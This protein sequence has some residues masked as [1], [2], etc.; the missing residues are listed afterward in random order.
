M[1]RRR[2]FVLCHSI[3]PAGD[4]WRWIDQDVDSRLIIAER[5][6]PALQNFESIAAYEEAS[7]E[8]E[9]ALLDPPPSLIFGAGETIEPGA[10]PKRCSRCSCLIPLLPRPKVQVKDY[11][12]AKLKASRPKPGISSDIRRK[13]VG[14]SS[15]GGS[16]PYRCAIHSS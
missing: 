16:L 11:I 7:V 9:V 8:A 3:A 15:G 12:Y 5:F 13:K 2:H 10:G 6:E 4:D 1:T 14:N